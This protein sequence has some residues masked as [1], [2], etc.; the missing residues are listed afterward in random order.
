MPENSAPFYD[1]LPLSL[2]EAQRLIEPGATDRR[3]EAH[4]PSVATLD[5]NGL[6]NQ[7]VMILRHVDWA[8]RKLRFHTDARSTKTITLS[9]RNAASVLFYLPAAK[10]QLRLNGTISMATTGDA[11]D[12]IGRAHV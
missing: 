8:A 5:A 6:P 1:D 11:I 4:C 2:I 12:E 3:S 7:R 9:E 10:I